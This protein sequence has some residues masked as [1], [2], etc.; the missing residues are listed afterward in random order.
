M[1]ALGLGERS[2][3]IRGWQFGD[4]ARAVELALTGGGVDIPLAALG[5]EIGESFLYQYNLFIPWEI[6][7]LRLQGA[8][9]S[10]V[11]ANG[12]DR[13][14]GDDDFTRSCLA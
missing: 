11:D 4:P 13:H 3:R 5:F 1:T 9:E 14:Q 2:T 10:A 6:D 7:C 12:G 8:V